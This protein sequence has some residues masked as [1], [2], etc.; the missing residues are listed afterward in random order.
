MGMVEQVTHGN[1]A[2]STNAANPVPTVTGSVHPQAVVPG[3][4]DFALTVVGANFVDGAVVNWNGSPRSTTFVSAREVQTKVLAADVTKP[5]AGYI[6]NPA[7][8]GGPSS[9]SHAIIEVHT[10]DKNHSS[11][12]AMHLPM[13]LTPA[14]DAVRASSLIVGDKFEISLRGYCCSDS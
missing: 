5:M 13:F 12:P 8:G 2:T 14:P 7:P 4:G 3:R 1:D 9:S 10:P 11:R 6:T